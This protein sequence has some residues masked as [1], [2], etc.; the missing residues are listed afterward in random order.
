MITYDE[1]MENILTAQEEMLK[2]GIEANSVTLNGKKYGK[3]IE[4]LPPN[5]KPTIFGMAVRA[6]YSMPDDYDF[7]VQHEQPQPKTKTVDTI[8]TLSASN[9]KQKVAYDILNIIKT[10]AYS[11]R[12]EYVQ[13]RVN[14]G[15]KGVIDA[16]IQYI[17]DIYLTD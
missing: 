7:F 9:E 16:I 8:E 1:L 3:L 6:E 4:N 14:N 11:K 13:F 2:R 12:P 10:Y 15:S 17:I 5:M